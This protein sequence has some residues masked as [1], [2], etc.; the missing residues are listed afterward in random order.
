MRRLLLAW[1]LLWPVTVQAQQKSFNLSYIEGMARYAYTWTDWGKLEYRVKFEVPE[2]DLRASMTDFTAYENFEA[3]SEIARRLEAKAQQVVPGV[4]VTITPVPAGIQYRAVGEKPKAEVA[5]QQVRELEKD[6]RAAYLS[7]RLYTFARENVLMPDH[8][9]IASLYA[10]KMAGL[11][12]ALLSQLRVGAT[13]RDV[14]DVG[15]GFFQTIPYDTLKDRYTSN[16][17]GFETPLRMLAE[18]RGDCDS[19]SVAYLALLRYY[20]PTLP[21]LMVYTPYHAF[22]G[23]GLPPQQN[24][25][26][27]EIEGIKYILAEPV[28]P[29]QVPVGK[30]APESMAELQKGVYS[31]R[32]VPQ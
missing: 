20:Y 25:A 32:A 4:K 17:A 3:N 30:I 9:R 26:T 11:G 21:L 12:K 27:V 5:M 13:A 28:G 29:T 31:W 10:P 19:K 8:G 16:G 24:D 1:L 14:M 23:I 6:V 15:I 22:V 18:N 7:E 2:D